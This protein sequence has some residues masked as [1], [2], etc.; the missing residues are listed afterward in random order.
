VYGLTNTLQQ[1]M[2]GVVPGLSGAIRQLASL[3]FETNSNN[4]TLSTTDTTTLNN[5]LATNLAGVQALFTN[6]NTGLAVQ[7][8]TYLTQAISDTGS[9]A[10]E[11]TSLTNQS[12]DITTQIN[13]IQAQAQADQTK[14]TNEFIA[15]ETAESQINSQMAYLNATFGLNGS[16]SGASSSS[17]STSSSG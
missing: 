8:N 17:S 16:T 15:M 1:T 3:G 9:L 2:N 13:A 11:E 10:T 6:A 4:A 5:A 14:Y 7:M 12:K